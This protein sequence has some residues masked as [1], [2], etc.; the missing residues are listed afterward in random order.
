LARRYAEQDHWEVEQTLEGEGGGRRF[1]R[2]ADVWVA[3]VALLVAGCSSS[4]ES[5]LRHRPC[6]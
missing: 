2:L 6:R 5:L 3:A 4:T 1:G